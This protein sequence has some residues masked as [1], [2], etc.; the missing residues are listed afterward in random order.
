MNKHTCVGRAWS[1]GAF[2]SYECGKTAAYEHDGRWYCKT[3]HPPTIEAKAKAKQE[4]RD[5]KWR[6]EKSLRDK[7]DAEHAEM[8]RRAALF[9]ELLEALVS[10]TKSDYIK[11]QHPRRYAAAIAIIA[12]V[13]VERHAELLPTLNVETNRLRKDRNTLLNQLQSLVT[14]AKLS[15]FEGATYAEI[16]RNEI[17]TAER[18]CQRI[19]A[20]A[21]GQR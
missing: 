11:K 7:A 4:E 8:K 18:L 1:P 3:H 19:R 9:P 15:L 21:E 6:Y 10:F 16:D 12:K 20:K 5:R 17:A 14:T 13:E 2:R